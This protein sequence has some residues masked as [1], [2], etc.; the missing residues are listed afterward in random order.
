[1]YH[2]AELNLRCTH[3]QLAQALV[4]D[5][6][7]LTYQL[8]K[9]VAPLFLIG[10]NDCFFV[11]SVLSQ[12]Q[13]EEEHTHKGQESYSDWPTAQKILPGGTFPRWSFCTFG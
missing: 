13:T 2:L 9:T 10:W 1:M 12:P 11:S 4:N 7:H 5:K 8:T 6:F 3:S